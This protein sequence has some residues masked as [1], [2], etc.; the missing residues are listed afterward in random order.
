MNVIL[1]EK[2]QE[3]INKN[4]ISNLL[5]KVSFLTEG[6]ILIKEPKIE[7]IKDKDIINYV[8]YNKISKGKLNVFIAQNFNE[9]FGENEEYFLELEGTLKKKLIIKNIKPIIIR[10][11]QMDDKKE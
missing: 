10:T 3:Y 8:D 7:I 6:C 4:D 9:I 1:S 2:A 5:I 11:C